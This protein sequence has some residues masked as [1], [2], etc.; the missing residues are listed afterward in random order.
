M[1]CPACKKPMRVEM[2]IFGGCVGHDPDERCYC[3][4]TDA[5]VV[6]MCRYIGPRDGVCRRYGKSLVIDG[7]VDGLSICAW[8]EE[9]IR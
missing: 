3:S 6:Y 5:K 7:M 8:I 1:N 2:Q 4:D 9:R